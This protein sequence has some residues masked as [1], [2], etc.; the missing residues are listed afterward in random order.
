MILAVQ[1]KH[2]NCLDWAQSNGDKMR[3]SNTEYTLE[4]KLT[5]L[6]RKWIV[7]RG[8]EEE[9]ITDKFQMYSLKQLSGW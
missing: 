4:A 3:W 2:G 1:M 9:I 7:Q 6:L 5:G 8:E